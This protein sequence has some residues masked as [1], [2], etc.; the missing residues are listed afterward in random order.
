MTK[1]LVIIVILIYFI[2]DCIKYPWNL[3]F[4]SILLLELCYIMWCGMV[5]WLGVT[6]EEITVGNLGGTL[7]K[8]IVAMLLEI[9]V[10]IIPIET[11][12]NSILGYF[13]WHN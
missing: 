9:A 6:V 1:L 7:L 5:G 2:S 12:E 8:I 10:F 11:L 4:L 13:C 3:L